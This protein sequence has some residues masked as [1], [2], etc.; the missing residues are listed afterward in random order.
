[1][2]VC[3]EEVDFGVEDIFIEGSF[4]PFRPQHGATV[5]CSTAV[6]MG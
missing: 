5:V 1:M 3:E 4:S 6:W 2:E